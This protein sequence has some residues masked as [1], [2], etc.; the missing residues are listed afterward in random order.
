[1]IPSH[2]MIYSPETENPDHQQPRLCDTQKSSRGERSYMESSKKAVRD[3]F[4]LL[5]NYQS[6]GIRENVLMRR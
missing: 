3:I 1:M 6:V 4:P 5:T 2:T